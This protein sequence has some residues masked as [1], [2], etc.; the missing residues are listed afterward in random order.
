MLP[1]AMGSPAGAGTGSSSAAVGP[2]RS[3]L[4]S[5][6]VLKFLEHALGRGLRDSLDLGQLLEQDP[7][8]PPSRRD[9]QLDD[10]VESTGHESGESDV[11]TLSE[12]LGGLARG[13]DLALELD[14]TGYPKP[15][16]IGS[17]TAVTRMKP[18]SISC[19]ARRATVDSGAA[20]RAGDLAPG[21][22]AVHLEGGGDAAVEIVH[23]IRY[24]CELPS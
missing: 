7:R 21:G 3:R 12:K 6:A 24:V 9:D 15:Q 13:S 4:Q 14:Q 16:R 11:R 18:P 17:A 22:A 1:G 5:Y 20:H 8:E 23:E 19:W 2:S 10:H